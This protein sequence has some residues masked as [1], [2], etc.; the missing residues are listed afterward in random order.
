MA[1]ALADKSHDPVEQKA[2]QDLVKWGLPASTLL[3]IETNELLAHAPVRDEIRLIARERGCSERSAIDSLYQF[4][5]SRRR[6][7]R[8]IDELLKRA[9]RR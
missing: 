8:G 1:V 9:R 2:Q 6:G 5:G 3:E 7:Q 4:R